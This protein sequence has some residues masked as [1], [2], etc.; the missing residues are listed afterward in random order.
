M[1]LDVYAMCPCGS[2]KKL[3]FC[4][5][6]LA[7]EIDLVSRMLENSQLHAAEQ[8]LDQLARKHPENPWAVV[9]HAMIQLELNEP[10]AARDGL[11]P[12]LTKLADNE[13]VILLYATASFHAD[14][15]DA[16]KSAIHR[17]FQKCAKKHPQMVAAL[18]DAVAASMLSNGK[19]LAAREHLVLA[20]RLAPE[21]D[22]QEIFV[23]LLRFDGSE[24]EPYFLRGM[25]PLPA[26]EGSEDEQKDHRLAV[27]YGSVGCWDAA[28]D[29]L[30]KLAEAAPDKATRWHAVGLARAFDGDE[31]RAAQALHRAAEIY[32]DIGLAVECKT[33]AI[34]LDLNHSENTIDLIAH[35]VALTSVSRVLTSLDQESRLV[36]MNVPPARDPDEVVPVAVYELLDRPSPPWREIAC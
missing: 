11:K 21:K 31:I 5:I 32:A 3:K 29:L 20:M 28:A 19:P 26:F 4:C 35:S 7:D 16:S 2:G 22:R 24:T 1:A 23:Q 25:H 36:R 13:L 27:R 17:A 33:L 8:R 14:G 9:T 30:T 18:A 15:Y 6:E 10:A 34:Q 12:A